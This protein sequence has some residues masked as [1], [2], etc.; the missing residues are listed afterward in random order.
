MYIYLRQ[1]PAIFHI[2]PCIIYWDIVETKITQRKVFGLYH[3]D[4]TGCWTCCLYLRMFPS[5]FENVTLKAR[6]SIYNKVVCRWRIRV[7]VNL[8]RMG[9]GLRCTIKIYNIR[10]K[11]GVGPVRGVPM[12]PVSVAYL[13]PWGMS[14]LRNSLYF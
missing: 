2:I 10:R 12:S 8:I 4:G 1:I 9:F 11:G 13:W 7:F 3:A 6:P 14:N 5:H